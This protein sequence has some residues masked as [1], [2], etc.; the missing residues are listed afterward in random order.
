MEVKSF[1]N[2][3]PGFYSLASLRRLWATKAGSWWDVERPTIVLI[4]ET[5]NR[6]PSKKPF[7]RKPERHPFRGYC[8]IVTACIHISVANLYHHRTPA[9]HE[10]ITGGSNSFGGAVRS[11]RISHSDSHEHG[12][13]SRHPHRYQS[14]QGLRVEFVI[15]C[16]E[17]G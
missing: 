7:R 14:E 1:G 10:R 6:S 5:T 11:I 16:T 3:D 17:V 15:V 4:V 8:S 9:C 2:S 12:L 13:E